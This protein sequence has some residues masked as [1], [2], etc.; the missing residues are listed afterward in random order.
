MTSNYRALASEVGCLSAEIYKEIRRCLR[1]RGGVMHDGIKWIWKTSE[2]LA[3]RLG[4]HE[5]T[6]RRHLKVLVDMG[7]LQR[8]QLQ[9]R[10]GM[11]AYHYCLG[12][13]APLKPAPVELLHGMQGVKGSAVSSPAQ[14]P[15]QTRRLRLVEAEQMSA[16]C[17]QEHHFQ[18]HTSNPQQPQQPAATRQTEQREGWIRTHGG[19]SAKAADQKRSDLFSEPALAFK[20][21][22]RNDQT[23][24]SLVPETNATTTA[25]PSHWPH[26][27]MSL[28]RKLQVIEAAKQLAFPNRASQAYGFA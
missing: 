12:D 27:D 17:E 13:N 28:S 3:E 8:E 18:E 15:V 23:T 11:R 1:L 10:W 9:K 16:S 2:E 21:R 24:R 14:M 19:G 26:D 25:V 7:W 5:K 6:I 20:T 4:C 22:A